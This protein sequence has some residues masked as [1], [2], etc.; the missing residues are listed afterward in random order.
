MYP[1]CRHCADD[2]VHFM[3]TDCHLVPCNLCQTPEKPRA[4]HVVKAEGAVQA[5][6]AF[7]RRMHA[8]RKDW[9]LEMV[10]VS[11]IEDEANR[12]EKEH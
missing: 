4:E 10:H 5:L 3:A 1:C 12:I 6:R 11:E 8:E 9:V 2:P 7:A